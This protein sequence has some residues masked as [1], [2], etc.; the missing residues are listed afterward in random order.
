MTIRDQIILIYKEVDKAC[1]AFNPTCRAGICGGAIRDLSLN[2]EPK[3]IDIFILVDDNDYGGLINHLNSFNAESSVFHKVFK[4]SE[5]KNIAQESC[6]YNTTIHETSYDTRLFPILREVLF[7]FE[8][9]A[10]IKPEKN[11]PCQVM[12]RKRSDCR[13]FISLIDTFDWNICQYGIFDDKFYDLNPESYQLTFNAN[14]LKAYENGGDCIASYCNKLELSMRRGLKFS[15]R[16]NIAIELES[17][18]FLLEKLLD[19]MREA[20]K[21]ITNY[22][23]F[24]WIKGMSGPKL[25]KLILKVAPPSQE[26]GELDF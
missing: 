23:Q 26:I 13:D 17:H 4:Y 2:R 18:L 6:A 14:C 1:Q 10:D 16:Y 22:R 12:V 21:T 24:S 8:N 11:L 5:P 20:S 7:R 19:T 3:D 25:P 9:F 15:E